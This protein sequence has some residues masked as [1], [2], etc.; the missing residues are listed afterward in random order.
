M[1]TFVLVVHIILAVM[2]IGLVLIQHG[3]GADAGASFGGGG[4]ATVF[5]A[6]GSGNFL[7]RVTAILTALFFVTSL[8]L[9]VFAK[10]QTTDAYSLKSVQTTNSAPATTPETSPN[11]P[12]SSQ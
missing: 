10:K 3:K 5:G 1:H 6:S 9:A 2:I 7:T 12:K 11:A 4:A 8:S